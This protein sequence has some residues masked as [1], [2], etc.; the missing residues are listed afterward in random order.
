MDTQAV[1]R[2]LSERLAASAS[3]KAVYGEPVTVGGRTVVPVAKVCYAF[4]AGGGHGRQEHEGSGGGGGAMVA[5]WPAGALEVTAEGSRFIG[6]HDPRLLG[7]AMG[8]GFVLGAT[9][10]LATR[11]CR[12]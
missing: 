10:A 9:V 6:Y 2:D 5:A 4:G 12:R 7:I 3:I 8:T 11:I 1:L